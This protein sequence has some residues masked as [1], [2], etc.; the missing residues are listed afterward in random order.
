MIIAN[1]YVLLLGLS[2]E[3]HR[4]IQWRFWSCKLWLNLEKVQSMSL[5]SWDFHKAEH[6]VNSMRHSPTWF[7]W[8][9]EVEWFTITTVMYNNV[10]KWRGMP[11]WKQCFSLEK[12]CF[13][14]GISLPFRAFG[15]SY[16]YRQKFLIS[17]RAL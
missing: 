1:K 13:Q 17:N 7:L 14:S 9:L 15:V 12:D 4:C 16:S 6:R 11:E 3:V 2:N 8:T 10:R 5:I